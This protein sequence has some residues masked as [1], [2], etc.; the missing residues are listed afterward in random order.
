VKFSRARLEER[1]R[2]GGGGAGAG[3]GLRR[4]SRQWQR[5]SSHYA[6][7]GWLYNILV[8]MPAT[9]QSTATH[10]AQRGARRKNSAGLPAGG[11]TLVAEEAATE[12]ETE[13]HGEGVVGDTG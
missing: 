4:H 3:R 13:T 6:Q 5:H 10:G 12:S 7:D 8:R 11:A 9:W 2:G 1:V